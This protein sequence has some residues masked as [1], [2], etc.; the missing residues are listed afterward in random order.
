MSVCTSLF[1]SLDERGLTVDKQNLG[2]VYRATATSA[3]EA[4]FIFKGRESSLAKAAANPKGKY[5][6]FYL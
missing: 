3:K 5:K 6:S 2:T 4:K 1:D